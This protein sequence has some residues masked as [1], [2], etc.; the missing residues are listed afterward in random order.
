MIYYILGGIVLL[1]SLLVI[2]ALIER[3]YENNGESGEEDE[4]T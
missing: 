3:Y 4:F 2:F 1:Y